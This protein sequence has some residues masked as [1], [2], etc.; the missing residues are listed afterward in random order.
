MQK[1]EAQT[2]CLNLILYR[3]INSLFTRDSNH[4]KER[5]DTTAIVFVSHLPLRRFQFIS[6]NNIDKKV[7]LIKLCNCHGDVI[8]L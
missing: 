5:T 1:R 8:P 3:F 4:T 7:K 2:S 6:W